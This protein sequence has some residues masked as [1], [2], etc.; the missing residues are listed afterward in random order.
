[1]K[2]VYT[3]IFNNYDELKQPVKTKGWKYICFTDNP[4][5]YE[6]GIWQLEKVPIID[7]PKKTTCYYITHG[8]EIFNDI[9]IS[10]TGQCEIIGNLDEFIEEFL[11]RDYCLV[12]HPDRNCTY[13]EGEA[14]INYKRDIPGNVIP[15]MRRYKKEGLP[16]NNGLVQCAVIGRRNTYEIKEFET[17]WWDELNKET[18][19]AQ[20]SF[21]YVLWKNP[22]KVNYFD[23]EDMKKYITIH[24]HLKV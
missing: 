21:N 11:I 19:R 24:K 9:V 2:T 1:M 7:N 6:K 10:I 5:L 3:F 22:I 17:L 20:L 8:L 15:Q 16:E 23:L 12:R 4:D 14:V 13:K 18:L